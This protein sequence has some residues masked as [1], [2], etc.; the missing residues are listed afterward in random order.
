M[1]LITHTSSGGSSVLRYCAGLYCFSSQADLHDSTLRLYISITSSISTS[2]HLICDINSSV[3][4]SSAGLSLF[5]SLS[6]VASSGSRLFCENVF[7]NCLY[8]LGLFSCLFHLTSTSL[9]IH[10][11]N[12]TSDNWVGLTSM[13]V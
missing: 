10:V 3:F 4:N 9:S 7:L 5:L 2:S 13:W 8:G 1:S 12:S 11:V 6:C